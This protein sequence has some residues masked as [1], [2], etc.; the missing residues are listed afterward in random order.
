M[1]CAEPNERVP[2]LTGH[3][4]RLRCGVQAVGAASTHTIGLSMINGSWSVLEY[5]MVRRIG[6]FARISSPFSAA[7]QS[8]TYL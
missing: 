4:A 8:T 5:S 6:P 2:L 7:R 1:G 3:C